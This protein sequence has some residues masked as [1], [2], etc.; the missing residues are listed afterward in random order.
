MSG[1]C[2]SLSF[3]LTYFLSFYLSRF[4]FY[5][6]TI[7]DIIQYEKSYLKWNDSVK[8]TGKHGLDYN[9]F[10]QN[11]MM[12]M[13]SPL[14]GVEVWRWGCSACSQGEIS[15]VGVG[16]SA[17][18]AVAPCLAVELW[19]TAADWVAP[20]LCSPSSAA[21]GAASSAAPTSS[22]HCATLPAACADPSPAPPAPQGSAPV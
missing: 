14:A 16:E 4:S 8:I 15:W 9:F 11:K 7:C 5:I 21:T 2:R 17:E 6:N 12:R 10:L 22:L 20:P 1:K 13:N 18:G 3:L 19:R